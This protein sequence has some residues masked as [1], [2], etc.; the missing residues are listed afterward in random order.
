ME[1]FSSWLRTE[2]FARK[3]YTT[4]D[5]AR[6]DVF[7][8]IERF[9]TPAPAGDTLPQ[10][11]SAPS[12]SRT[13]L[14]WLNLASERPAVAQ[15]STRRMASRSTVFAEDFNL[16][17]PALVHV[18]TWSGTDER[19]AAYAQQRPNCAFCYRRKHFV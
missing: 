6:A 2:R 18:G 16:A 5:E 10:G 8:Y 11:I 7:D 9:Y 17:F 19:Y 15:A 13:E 1:S 12:S 4:R 3:V 14:R